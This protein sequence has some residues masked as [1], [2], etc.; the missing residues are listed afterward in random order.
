M[1]IYAK[2]FAEK[3]FNATCVYGDTDSV[4]LSFPD[5]IKPEMSDK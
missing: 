2:E 1:L 3:H 4:F 5:H